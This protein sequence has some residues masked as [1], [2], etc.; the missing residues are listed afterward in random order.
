MSEWVEVMPCR[1]FSESYLEP[2]N[3]L[4]EHTPAEKSN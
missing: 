4:K 2:L 1:E 3:N